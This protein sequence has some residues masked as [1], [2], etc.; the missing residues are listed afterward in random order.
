MVLLWLGRSF[1]SVRS[2]PRK[3]GLDKWVR[4]LTTLTAQHEIPALT[5]AF[6]N[7]AH[8]LPMVC[9][10]SLESIDCYSPFSCVVRC[11][12]NIFAANVLL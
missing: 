10:L 6:F 2:G 1:S 12:T 4:S 11:F 7:S 3:K 9:A 5:A 8:P